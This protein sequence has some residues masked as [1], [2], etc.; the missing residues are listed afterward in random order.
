MGWVGVI[1]GSGGVGVIKR[2]SDRW[3]GVIRGW[4]G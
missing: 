2:W 3:V 4:G 1:R